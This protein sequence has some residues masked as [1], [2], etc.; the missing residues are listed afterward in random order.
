MSPSGRDSVTITRS[1]GRSRLR[2]KNYAP[3]QSQKR[4]NASSKLFGPHLTQ[5]DW[6]VLHACIQSVSVF[7][8]SRRAKLLL[9]TAVSSILIS[10][11][12]P[13]LSKVE[14]VMPLL[15]SQSPSHCFMYHDCSRSSVV[16]L[17]SPRDLVAAHRRVLPDHGREVWERPDVYS[18]C[19]E[20]PQFYHI[21]QQFPMDLGYVD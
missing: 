3:A 4:I 19:S 15:C 11:D 13:G 20:V 2:S 17:V 14:I 6:P 7:S 16:I 18:Y 5:N 10:I 21:V 1:K 12:Q 9:S 8:R